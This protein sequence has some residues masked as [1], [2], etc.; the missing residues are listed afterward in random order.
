MI[1]MPWAIYN[2]PSIQLGSL[3]AYVETN[4]EFSAH[5]FHPYLDIAAALGTDLYTTISDSSWAGEAVFSALLFEEKYPEAEKLFNKSLKKSAASASDRPVFEKTVKAVEEVCNRWLAETD[6]SSFQLVGVSVCFNQLLASL[7]I[8]RKISNLAGSPPIVFGGSSCA[9]ELGKSL[10]ATFPWIDFVVDGEGEASLVDLLEYLT[11]QTGKLPDCIYSKAPV[12]TSPLS[13]EIT[14]LNA[15]PTPDFDHYFKQLRI[16]FPD[17]P[18][19]PI[20]PVEFS[21]GCWWNKCT[22]CNLNLQWHNYRAKNAEK[23]LSELST[24]CK[25]F[26]CLDFT[27]CDNALPVGESKRFFDTMA[28]VEPDI[29]FFAEIRGTTS[30]ESLLAFRKGG[31]DTIQVGIESLS[32]SLLTRMKKGVTTIENL[33][34]MKHAMAAGIRLEGNLIV[35]FPGSTE[36]EVA[37]TAENIAYVLPFHPLSAAA[38][39]LGHGSPVACNPQEFGISAQLTHSKNKSLFPDSVLHTMTLLSSEYRGDRSK[40]KILWQPVRKKIEKWQEFHKLREDGQPPA[41]RYRDGGNFIIIRQELADAPPLRHK[42]TGLSRQIYI[43]CSEIR[44]LD[45]IKKQFN[46]SK[47]SAILAFIDQL[48]QKRLMF[49]EHSRVLSLAIRQRK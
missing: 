8:S 15:L 14:D 21:R 40:Q 5:C 47:D 48:C 28:Q 22:F 6:W 1:S 45:E 10:L 27:F 20:L 43:F 29:R 30:Y 26:Q 44:T 17:S 31:L 2:R 11:N 32:T 41:L 19:S 49:R 18:F 25:R 12:A 13:Q 39:F 3:K 24:L 34:I 46:S 38:F 33:A 16:T 9:G 42:L 7:Y 36:Q 23:M 37:E 4:S 35:E